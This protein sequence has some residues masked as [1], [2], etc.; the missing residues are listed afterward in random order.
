MFSVD[1]EIIWEEPNDEFLH[2]DMFRLSNGNYMGIV[3]I[4]SIGPVPLDP[5]HLYSSS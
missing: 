5:G 4:S 3:S 2:H 1:N